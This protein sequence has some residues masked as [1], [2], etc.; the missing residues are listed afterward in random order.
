VE[1]IKLLR[2]VEMFAGLTDPQLEKLAQV[3]EEREY[4]RDETLFL[5]GDP[6]SRLYLVRSGFVE[7]IVE[8]E[9]NP[10]GKTIIH[11]G[12]GQSVGEMAL[13][14][15]GARSA[16]VRATADHTQVASISRDSFEQVCA[17]DTALGY[18]VM[19]NIAADL[20]FRLR[21][22]SYEKT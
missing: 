15:Q 10:Q 1:L 5:Q 11:L 21:R 22:K 19:R 14:D 20:S 8:S 13:V 16:T 2:A 4:Q 6:A 17:A 3:F 7:V 12:A 9:N 18:Q